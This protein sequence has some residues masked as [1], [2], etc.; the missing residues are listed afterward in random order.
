MYRKHTSR[1]A[2]A[3]FAVSLGVA[4]LIGLMASAGAG[5]APAA[6]PTVVIGSKNFTEQFILGQLYKQALQ[7]KGYTVKYSE[8]I[9]SS[10]LIDTAL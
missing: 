4:L 3:S 6:K 9:G 10:V 1:A 5:A 2:K 7:A 8:N